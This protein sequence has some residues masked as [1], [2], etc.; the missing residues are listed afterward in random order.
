MTQ[1]KKPNTALVIGGGIV[2]L[3]TALYLQRQGVQVTLIERQHIG[4][5]ASFGNA[6]MLTNT[7]IIPVAT[8]GLTRKIPF[9]LTNPDSPLRVTKGHLAKNLR[10]FFNFWRGA[11]HD[12][13]RY[14]AKLLNGLLYDAYEQ[15][16]ALADGTD[17]SRYLVYRPTITPFMSEKNRNADATVWDIRKKLCAG[18]TELDD[19]VLREKM[20]ALNPKWTK[21][22]LMSNYGSVSNAGAYLNA[23]SNVFEKA[24]GTLIYSP[25][26]GFETQNDTVVGVTTN[27]GVKTADTY[28]ICA[29][30]YSHQLS[31]QLGDTVPLVAESGYHM[32]IC[33]PNIEIQYNILSGA[34]GMAITNVKN[35]LRC[36][37][38]AEYAG[39]NATPK[40]E[41]AD[42][43]IRKNLK[44]LLPDLRIKECTLW[45]GDRPS[46]SDSLP[47]IGRASQY[48]NVFYGFGHQHIGMSAGPKTGRIL[49]QIIC[50]TPPSIDIQG[51]SATRF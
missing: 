24:G 38:F 3:S 22:Y 10:W 8:P 29:G 2:G 40:Y 13:L 30:V 27:H 34:H 47:V 4:A 32:E 33:N 21:S 51:F 35:G 9:Y 45:R 43:M 48:D 15:H 19:G 49:S 18:I 12:A 42:R 39:L 14:R 11:N 20:P 31:E 44:D 1:Y 6:C 7:S 41:D 50:G 25:V 16:Q 37:I 26:L 36:T 5:G 46:T 17:A 23:L 28:A